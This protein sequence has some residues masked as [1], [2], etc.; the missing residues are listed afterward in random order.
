MLVV[1]DSH[2]LGVLNGGRGIWPRFRISQRLP[3]SG[4]CSCYGV[5]GERNGVAGWGGFWRCRQHKRDPADG[6]F[7][8][9]FAN[10][11]GLSGCVFMQADTLYAE[12][13]GRL[14]ANYRLAEELLLPTGLFRHA[15]GYPVFYTEHDE[16]YS[17]LFQHHI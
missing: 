15:V 2:G 9:L 16:L 8:G 6:L 12:A 7:R 10:G 3:V 11:T 13:G 17:D 4:T 14:Q 1:D 5:A